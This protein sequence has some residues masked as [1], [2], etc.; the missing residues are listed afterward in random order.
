[1]LKKLT[2]VGIMA[3]AASGVML[4]GSPANADTSGHGSILGGNQI[5]APITVPIGVCGNSVAILGFGG[6]GCGPTFW[7][8]HHHHHGYGY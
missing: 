5:N 6:S 4:L 1:M 7:R 2:A 3:A 8:H